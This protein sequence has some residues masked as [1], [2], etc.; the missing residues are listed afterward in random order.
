MP[1]LTKDQTNMAIGMLIGRMPINC[2]VPE[3]TNHPDKKLDPLLI[4]CDATNSSQETI[5]E[6]VICL[7]K[8]LLDF[9]I[10]LPERTTGFPAKY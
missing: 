3:L 1:R 8:P 2:Y 5:C 10:P 6:S 7:V 9:F 4:C